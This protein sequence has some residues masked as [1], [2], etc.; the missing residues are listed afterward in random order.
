[1]PGAYRWLPRGAPASL[2]IDG[3]VVEPGQVV[4]FERGTHAATLLDD[5]SGGMLVLAL[6]EPPGEAPRRFYR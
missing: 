6:A 1:M 5:V 2:A 3:R 4:S